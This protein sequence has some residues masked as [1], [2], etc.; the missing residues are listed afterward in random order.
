MRLGAP[1]IRC[2]II[3]RRG[4]TPRFVSRSLGP[5]EIGPLD[6]HAAVLGSNGNIYLYGGGTKGHSN[7]DAFPGL[8]D[9]SWRGDAINTQIPP[10]RVGTQIAFLGVSMF[11]Y[12]GNNDG[13]VD[14]AAEDVVVFID[15][16]GTDNDG[17]GTAVDESAA[18][19]LFGGGR[20]E[21]QMFSFDDQLWLVGGRETTVGVSPPALKGD[22]WNSGDGENWT[23]AVAAADFGRRQE[24]VVV[25]HESAGADTPVT[26]FGIDSDLLGNLHV[27]AAGST[28]TD[29][30]I[31][32]GLPGSGFS[33]VK[34]H[35]GEVSVS[36]IAGGD[37]RFS[38]SVDTSK[39]LRVPFAPN[40][41]EQAGSVIVVT[42]RFTDETPFNVYDHEFRVSFYA[43]VS[44][45]EAT[46]RVDLPSSVPADGAVY[47]LTTRDGLPWNR[48]Y[49]VVSPF[50][51][52]GGEAT[53]S[54]AVGSKSGVM[55][56][57][58]VLDGNYL[59]DVMTVTAV[60]A[61]STVAADMATLIVEFNVAR[62]EFRNPSSEVLVGT[63]AGTRVAQLAFSVAGLTSAIES[64]TSG[65]GDWLGVSLDATRRRVPVTLKGP[66]ASAGVYRA[67]I[68]VS[69]RANPRL[70]FTTLAYTLRAVAGVSSVGGATVTAVG[71]YAGALVT[72]SSV[73][74]G[75]PPYS[76][77]LARAV[78]G[79]SIGEDGAVS[80]AAGSV[81]GGG[82][83]VTLMVSVG[84]N[85]GSSGTATVVVAGARELSLP[86]LF[87]PIPVAFGTIKAL[88]TLGG[89]V[90]GGA[91]AFSYSSD[92]YWVT[93]DA[94]GVVSMAAGRFL[95]ENDEETET[96]EE[97]V[98]IEV[99]DEALGRTPAVFSL[100]VRSYFPVHYDSTNRSVPVPG[101]VDGVQLLAYRPIAQGGA[102]FGFN[103]SLDSV[104]PPRFVVSVHPTDARFFV[105]T[106]MLLL[107]FD[108][109]TAVVR[110]TDRKTGESAVQTVAFWGS[111]R[112][113]L[114]GVE[115]DRYYV[116]TGA[117]API[118]L[119]TVSVSGGVGKFAYSATIDLFAPDGYALTDGRLLLTTTTTLT[120]TLHTV[121]LELYPIAEDPNDFNV[122][123]YCDRS[124]VDL[125]GQ[126][127][128][129]VLEISIYAPLSVMTPAAVTKR[130]GADSP[131]LTRLQAEGG[132]APYAWRKV[133]GDPMGLV[134]VTRGGTVAVV[135]F[136]MEGADLAV[137]VAV[138][139]ATG[140][141]TTVVLT[142]R[143][144]A[145]LAFP[146][147]ATK[148]VAI[149]Y[150]GEVFEAPTATGGGRGVFLWGGDAGL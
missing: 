89:T 32:V 61:D 64:I 93:V 46:V 60:A 28:V 146:A 54:V 57:P 145:P 105:G 90:S 2:I 42:V 97:T 55:T 29:N 71:D 126:C 7:A 135:N 86:T 125:G 24:H 85:S 38:W 141:V 43:P 76:F 114:K 132:V 124:R 78:S 34:G 129:R 82:E 94:A 112:P 150:V 31:L 127:Y 37:A 137:T 6:G 18:G 111:Y 116:A 14:V 107:A 83:Q 148:R 134:S 52:R 74:G 66:L 136:P 35:V 44:F 16:A 3:R 22:I 73:M 138:G 77:A 23:L 41:N 79:Y 47:T 5:N 147:Q 11:V 75:V 103:Y 117:T 80:V 81:P 36:V 53:L 40:G 102:G 131:L 56:V 19:T 142:V 33:A 122:E 69:T 21:H 144:V 65:D 139:D 72:V 110:A 123:G 140:P 13:D 120:P 96:L 8:F 115:E 104:V 149:G 128:Q 30:A 121:T 99:T 106:R 109:V 59:Y 143:L 50:Y 27:V 9:G 101:F 67:T 63:A 25:V 4:G 130:F 91:G 62:V 17:L 12:G 87:D 15:R 51:Y 48:E 39:L 58:Q 92:V 1:A 98:R 108:S 95:P 84:G 10:N 119:A 20:S 70:P 118:T 133:G 100:T 68:V 113:V 45:S 26:R 49:S 88:Y